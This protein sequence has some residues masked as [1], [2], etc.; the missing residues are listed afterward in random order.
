MILPHRMALVFIAALL[1]VGAR[2]AE[3]PAPLRRI[4]FGSCAKEDQPQPLWERVLA[5]KPDLFLFLG[6]NIYG[7]TED[8]GVL[9]TKYLRLAAQPG[10]RKLRRS[11][12]VLA[13]WDDHDYGVN[14]G[15][16][17]YPKRAESQQVFLDFFGE[18]KDSPRRRQAGV[19]AAR[20]YGPEG[21]RVQIILLDTR[22][23]RSPLRK[24]SP[25]DAALGPYV[26]DDGPAATVLGDAQWRWLEEQLR[27]P[28]ELRIIASS[29][30]V[31]PEDHGWEKWMNFPRER[32][33]LYRLI[34]ETA[35][36]GVVFLSGDRHLAELSLMD[37]GVGYPL[38]DLT[39]SAIN[40]SA[41]SWRP[42]ELNRHRVGT[43][44]SGDNFGLI[45][46]DWDRPDPQIH[47]QIRDA[48]GDI[49]IGRKINVSTLQ[50]KGK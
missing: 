40:R 42:Y 1:A 49:A 35:A 39:A 28:A 22:Y 15:G 50:P 41:K 25:P 46:I 17:E 45:T 44:N 24:R 43:M 8:M 5:A 34:R 32:E 19:Y 31:V 14:D 36:T 13:T 3:T 48:D 30:Q 12:P 16:R 9:R 26:P 4:A 20:V 29:I 37:G 27:T 6:D 7:D 38:Y 21:R 23:H 47:L 10:Y 18:P 2:A 11:C 33:R